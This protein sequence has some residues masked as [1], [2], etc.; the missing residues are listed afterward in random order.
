VLALDG[1]SLLAG[2]QT[3]VANFFAGDPNNRGGVHVAVKPAADGTPRLVTGSGAGEPAAVRVYLP[4]TARV[5]GQPDQTLTPFGGA[6]LAEG[7]F[8]G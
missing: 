3:P 8:V 5:A 4:R 6:T 2:T 7:V 1:K